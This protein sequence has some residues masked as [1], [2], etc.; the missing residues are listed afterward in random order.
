MNDKTQKQRLIIGITGASGIVYAIRLLE[1][2]KS[3]EQIET[4]LVISHAAKQ[5]MAVETDYSVQ[6]IRDLADHNY[7]VR[8]IGAAIS[9]GSYRTL[10]MVVVC[11]LYTSPSP[12]D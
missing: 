11:L 1:V 10:G 5:A 4:H 7:D 9:S 3:V 6:Q 12:R 2:L 8:D